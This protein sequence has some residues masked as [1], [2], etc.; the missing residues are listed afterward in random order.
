M[1]VVSIVLPSPPASAVDKCVSNALKRLVSDQEVLS[2]IDPSLVRANLALDRPGAGLCGPTCAFNL[3]EALGKKMGLRMR[4]STDPVSE[5]S[6]VFYMFDRELDIRFGM[7]PELMERYIKQRFL[8]SGISVRVGRRHHLQGL[9]INDL[10]QTER[11]SIISW[12]EYGPSLEL[13]S[14]H[15]VLVADIDQ[16]KKTITIIDPGYPFVLQE[17]PYRSTVHPLDFTNTLELDRYGRRV[18]L[19]N[20]LS[21]DGLGSTNIHASQNPMVADRYSAKPLQ[22]SSRI[23]SNW[24]DDETNYSSRTGQW[25]NPATG[26]CYGWYS[27]NVFKRFGQDV[28]PYPEP[29]R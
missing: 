8:D 14:S 24:L 2:Q 7:P 23:Q 1:S 22:S 13:L 11:A 21:I 27:I 25:R 16:I 17:L 6:S 5:M 10:D 4:H 20:V 12:A 3:F 18:V 15:Y 19:E 9:S 28:M 29:C 26:D